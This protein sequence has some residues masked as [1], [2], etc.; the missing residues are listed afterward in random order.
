L[1]PQ[2]IHD[3]WLV[4]GLSVSQKNAQNGEKTEVNTTPIDA[5][6]I[7]LATTPDPNTLET[8]FENSNTQIHR[9]AG[10]R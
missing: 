8:H 4:E 7:K 1:N 9:L 2:S 6:T 5:K 3:Q 10:N